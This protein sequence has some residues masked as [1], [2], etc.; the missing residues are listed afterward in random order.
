MRALV[1]FDLVGAAFGMCVHVAIV[2]TRYTTMI[3]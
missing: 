1:L 2:T 3:G